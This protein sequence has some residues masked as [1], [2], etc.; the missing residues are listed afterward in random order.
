M[1]TTYNLYS[2]LVE[3][4]KGNREDLLQALASLGDFDCDFNGENGIEYAWEET[5]KNGFES[6]LEYLLNEVK[7]IDND[8]DCVEKFISMWMDED[9]YYYEHD[10][11][12][13]ADNDGNV[14]A[15]SLA[16]MVGY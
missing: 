10:L 5:L 7:N 16:A 14:Y 15:I 1:S 2:N 4:E 11:N 9:N 3:V 12:C 8:I 13:L 6:N